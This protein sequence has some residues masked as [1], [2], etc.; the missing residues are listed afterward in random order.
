M[1]NNNY[2]EIAI[3]EAKK[4]IR[5]GHGGPFGAVIV[6]DDEIVARGH[7]RVVE[8]ND[9]TAHGE[10][11][12]IR[13]AT[14]KLNTFDLSG[15]ELY[16]T[17]YPCPMCMSAIIW[18]NIKK[19]YY[20]CNAKD[21]EKIGF[22]DDFIYQFIESGCNNTDLLNIQEVSREDGLKLFEE[23]TNIVDKTLY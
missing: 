15:C 20:S 22:R 2:M 12:A 9:P 11:V 17:G 18:A 7:N 19:V 16:T 3:E 1:P 6:K 5:K 23:Y 10:I 8:T 21:A 14:K 13:E 4:G